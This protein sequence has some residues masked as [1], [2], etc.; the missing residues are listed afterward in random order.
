VEEGRVTDHATKVV[1]HDTASCNT[2][3]HAPD[4]N[5]GT[6]FEAR[7]SCGFGQGASCREHAEVIAR[8]HHADPEAP[9]IS[10]DN[11]PLTCS[12]VTVQQLR[13]LFARHCECRPLD[14]ERGEG[15]HSH[16]C[17]TEIL[18]DVQI[19][20]GFIL[21]DDIGRAQTNQQARQR[22]ADFINAQREA[23]R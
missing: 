15:D 2:A 11:T 16:D 14:L 12:T 4:G 7:C 20:L 13:D 9:V 3:K 8:G 19:A 5:C 6:R 23:G 10:W 1:R 17:D 21:F 18:H 22:C